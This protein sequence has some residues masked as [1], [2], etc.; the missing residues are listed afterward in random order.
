MPNPGSCQCVGDTFS[1]DSPNRYSVLWSRDRRQGRLGVATAWLCVCSTPVSLRQI[2]HNLVVVVVLL[3]ILLGMSNGGKFGTG[4][5]KSKSI[6]FLVKERKKEFSLEISRWG[7]DSG[8]VLGSRCDEPLS[9][10]VFMA[11]WL[12]LSC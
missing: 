7:F 8:P 11:A 5:D 6:M 2:R 10:G 4:I 3:S 1:A 12:F 9:L